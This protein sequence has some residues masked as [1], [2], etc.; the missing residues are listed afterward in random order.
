[1]LPSHK[2]LDMQV[3]VLFPEAFCKQVLRDSAR[4]YAAQLLVCGK[5][6][7]C[8]SLR[9]SPDAD[10]SGRVKDS[11]EINLYTAVVLRCGF[12]GSRK[13]VNQKVTLKIMIPK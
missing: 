3:H 10:R 13:L 12:G 5:C 1:M 9:A 11:S 6:C 2:Q 8:S 7:V 4:N